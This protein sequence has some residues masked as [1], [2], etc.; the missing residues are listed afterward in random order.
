M[1]FANQLLFSEAH[2]AYGNTW[3]RSSP[4]KGADERC[5]F[6]C[7]GNFDPDEEIFNELQSNMKFEDTFVAVHPDDV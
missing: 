3:S 1:S 4:S 7:E 5:K 6:Q 2:S